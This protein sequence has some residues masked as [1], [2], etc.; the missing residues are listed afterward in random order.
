MGETEDI[1]KQVL[2]AAIGS[3]VLAMQEAEL[4][5]RRLQSIVAVAKQLAHDFPC[6]CWINKP[7]CSSCQLFELTKND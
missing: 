4:E 7:K 1:Q 6:S 5:I 2:E 3:A